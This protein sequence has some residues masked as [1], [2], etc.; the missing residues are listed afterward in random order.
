MSSVKI[1]L[2]LNKKG[3]E[4]DRIEYVRGSPTP[5]G[6]A[7]GW[8]IDISDKVEN[9]IYIANKCCKAENFMQFDNL[10]QVYKW[11]NQLPNLVTTAPKKIETDHD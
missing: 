5:T 1:K 6:Y 3:I 8:D 4:A 7:Q 9:A 11:I 10:E 2:E